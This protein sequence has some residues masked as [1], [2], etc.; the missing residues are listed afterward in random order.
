MILISL[1]VEFMNEIETWSN[2]SS[3]E[4]III[5]HVFCQLTFKGFQAVAT[6]RFEVRCRSPSSLYHIA[7]EGDFWIAMMMS[8]NYVFD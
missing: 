4:Y 7:C 1:Q 8:K 5:K 3:S 2:E 6:S